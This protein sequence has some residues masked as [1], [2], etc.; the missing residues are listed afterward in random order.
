MKARIRKTCE[1]VD[2]I[3]YN[4]CSTI[5]SH[6]DYFGSIDYNKETIAKLAVEQ[7]DVLIEQLKSNQK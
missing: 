4:T 5:R 6:Q 7:A 2:V 1:I 3:S